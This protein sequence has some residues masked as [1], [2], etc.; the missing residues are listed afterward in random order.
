MT[1]DRLARC[2]VAA[3]LSCGSLAPAGGRPLSAQVP[4]DPPSGVAAAASVRSGW[5][6]ARVLEL[7]AGARD[8]RR[9]SA[10][11]GISSYRADAMGRV[12]FF[13]DRPD[14]DEHLLVKA[15]QVALELYWEAPDRAKQRIVGQRDQ[16]VL[17]TSIRYHLDHL[18][19]VQ[20]DFGD[21]IRLGDGDE[22]A[23]VTHPAAP[24][25]P[26]VYD[27][28]LVDSLSIRYGTAGAEVRVY[29]IQVRPRRFER[30]GYVGTIFLDRATSAIVR[31]NFS[32]T[33]ASYVDPALDY[34]RISL[35]NSLW[36]GRHWLP[37]RQEVEL[38]REIPV[39]DV[40]AGSVIRSR[41]E[42]GDYE[43]D[44]P[45]DP[46]VFQGPRIGALPP[47]RRATFPF[48]EGL[49]DEI[50]EEGL[51]MSTSLEEVREQVREVVEDRVLSGLSPI[52]VS[53]EG[54]SDFARYDRAEGLYLGGGVTLRPRGSLSLRTAAGYAFG[55]RRPSARMS[56][57][58]G[59]DGSPAFAAYWDALGDIGG[60]PGAEPLVNTMTAVSG[61]KDYLDPYFRRGATLTLGSRDRGPALSLRW[62]DQRSATDVV[63]GTRDTEFRPV[64]S[65][66]EGH[67]AAATAILGLHLPG[68]GFARLSA[69]G[70]RLGN[71]SLGTAKLETEWRLGAVQKR[72]SAA[73][74][75]EGALTNPGAP[76]QELHM[77]GGRHTLPG[78]D[79]RAFLGNAYWLA[80]MEGTVPVRPPW[81]GIRAFAVAGAT[82]L[83]SVT[84]PADWVATDS[85]G[86]R[87]SVGLGLSVG[88]DTVFLD[89]AHGIRGGAWEAVVSVAR[90]FR[91]WM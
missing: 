66:V 54:V 33:P 30:P 48:E 43:F 25:G 38:R 35:D 41:F 29:E 4:V 58:D 88:W 12:Y 65:I 1:W 69:T 34:I 45:L 90:P 59:D 8:A 57:V 87:G 62:E 53:F 89:V 3:L 72:W 40:S 79:Y 39:L 70:G 64:R 75:A 23:A 60:N 76:P 20:D 5:N 17:P 21:M 19:V 82:Y 22:V 49:F 63:S 27:Y 16:K 91:G 74:R 18:T 24:A 7:V 78:H 28:Q 83:G 73:L 14:S 9:A 56:L 81:V 50:A 44:V 46:S 13:V 47:S 67:L 37:Y 84:L 80:R 51:A 42:V 32:F 36:L 11:G 77:I 71:L 26:D 31:M 85:D 68:D 52:R 6:G 15:D 55:R 10:D 61:E 2:A 86:V